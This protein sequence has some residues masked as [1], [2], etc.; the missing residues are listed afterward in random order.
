MTTTAPKVICTECRH[1]NEAGIRRTSRR[2]ELLRL[3]QLCDQKLTSCQRLARKQF[4]EELMLLMTVANPALQPVVQKY[5]ELAAWLTLGKNQG[6]ATKLRDPDTFRTKISARMTEI[7]DYMNWFEATQLQTASGAFDNFKASTDPAARPRR[8][9][10]F[11]IYLDAAG[12]Q[13]LNDRCRSERQLLA[14]VLLIIMA[15]TDS[16][17]RLDLPKPLI[18]S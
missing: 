12:A 15:C 13:S 2:V 4:S 17:R 14:R 3:E 10:N 11:L 6:V 8:R 18:R 7:D 9:D 16:C 5:Q 1:E